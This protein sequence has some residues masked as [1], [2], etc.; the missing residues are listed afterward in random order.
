[1]RK[2]QAEEAKFSYILP[3]EAAF[4]YKHSEL[5]T[6]H[7]PSLFYFLT[8]QIPIRSARNAGEEPGAKIHFQLRIHVATCRR[9]RNLASFWE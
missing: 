4:T 6:H 9:K 1:M 8:F 3:D 7:F 5:C 2:R